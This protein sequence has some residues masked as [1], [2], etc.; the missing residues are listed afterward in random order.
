MY[1]PIID[2]LK[3]NFIA[4]IPSIVTQWLTDNVDPVG[5]AVVVDKSL[6]ISGAAADAKATGDEI[7]N[8]KSDL[9]NVIIYPNLV[10]PSECTIGKYLPPDS[11]QKTNSTYDFTN[12]ISVTPGET[13]YLTHEGRY[14]QARNASNQRIDDAGLSSGFTQ[15]TVPEGIAIVY[16]TFYHEDFSDFMVSKYHDFEYIPYGEKVI[17]EQYISSLSPMQEQIAENTAK[18]SAIQSITSKNGGYY[19]LT[20][21]IT[22]NGH[23]LIDKMLSVQKNVVLS[24]VGNV[25]TTFAGIEIGFTTNITQSDQEHFVI[26]DTEITR[27][28]TSPTT[29]QHGITIKDQL[30]VTVTNTIDGYLKVKIESNGQSY[31]SSNAWRTSSRKPYVKALGNMTD[32]VFTWTCKDNSKDIALFGDSYL[33]FSNERWRYYLDADGYSDNT[34]VNSYAGENSANGVINFDN[35]TPVIS[36]KFLFWGYGMNDH[37]SGG[38]Y[39][40]SWKTALEHVLEYCDNH[41]ITPILATIPNVPQYDNTAKNTYIRNSGRRYIDFAKAVGSDVSSAWFD[42][43]LSSDN[44]HPTALGA[45]ALYHRAIVDFPELAITN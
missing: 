41:G 16:I 4:K 6:S 44:V 45:I 31:T 5:S 35:L 1:F 43:M 22:A 14:L 15:Y 39:N 12:P 26:T 33:S 37:D 34:F 24:F 30:C 27:V 10:N 32:C 8:L 11:T 38:A 25:G 40:A 2:A 42:G 9:N 29:A 19:R 18:I 28:T 7:G 21:D 36:P 23:L 13:L 3:E 17:N 20:G